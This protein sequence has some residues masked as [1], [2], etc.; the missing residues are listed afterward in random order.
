MPRLRHAPASVPAWNKYGV[1]SA[2]PKVAFACFSSARYSGLSS[3]EGGTRDGPAFGFE[4]RTVMAG[5][6]ITRWKVLTISFGS[7]PGMTR[8]LMVASAEPGM[9]LL[10]KPPSMITGAIVLRMIACISG[11]LLTSRSAA[12]S[13]AGSVLVNSVR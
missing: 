12:A 7:V 13:A 3:G 1:T 10:R 6:S 11:S 4:R 8:T 9:T 2:P 5:S